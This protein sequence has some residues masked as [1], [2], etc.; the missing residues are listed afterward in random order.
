MRT[1]ERRQILKER[2]ESREKPPIPPLYNRYQMVQLAVLLVAALAVAVMI[3]V[4]VAFSWTS[5]ET[6]APVASVAGEAI[7][8]GSRTITSPFLLMVNF[9]N[10]VGIKPKKLPW[11]SSGVDYGNTRIPMKASGKQLY[12][13]WQY[14]PKKLDAVPPG[15]NVLSP[16]WFYVESNDGKA[17][18]NDL[19]TLR[20]GKIASWTPEQY[21]KTAHAGGAQVW[22][23]VVS[24]DPDL[25]AQIVK[26]DDIRGAFISRIV[27]W[28]QEYNLD[29]INF[30][31]EKMDP[32]DKEKFTALVAQCKSA[33]PSDILVSVDVTVPLDNPSSTNWWQCYDRKGL[34][35]AADYVAVMAY[36]NPDMEPVAALDWVRDKVVA[37][38]DMVPAEKILLGVP[39]YGVDFQYD[40]PAG[41]VLDSVPDYKSSKSRST[42]SPNTVQTLLDKQAYTIGKKTFAVAYWIHKGLWSDTLGMM[43]YSFVDTTGVL[44]VIY[45]EDVQ[46]LTQ[47]GK[48][49][50]Y[51]RLGGAAVWKLEFG[52]DSLWNALLQGMSTN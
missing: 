34:G 3:V 24:M 33:L 48:L 23:S 1:R 41:K 16:T 26:D 51:E 38:L 32:A 6:S 2:I 31:F 46:S 7:A 12:M 35:Q 29:G 28:V 18:V 25:S 42:I 27:A 52:K 36:D 19:A 11:V 39:F 10:G 40:V 50:A 47:K 43:E 8:D 45:C 5:L 14:R 49:L 21:V 22:A 20:E 30:D 37:M 13:A 9:L 17:E 44:H 4:P 15:V